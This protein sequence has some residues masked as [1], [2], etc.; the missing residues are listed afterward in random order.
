MMV[1]ACVRMQKASGRIC[2]REGWIMGSVV[3]MRSERDTSGK[4][5]SKKEGI[6]TPQ[7][8]MGRCQ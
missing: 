8:E 1:V 5:T 6:G 4:M 7:R 2:H 3:E